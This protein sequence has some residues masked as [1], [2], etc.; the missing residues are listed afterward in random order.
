MEAHNAPR[1]QPW[2]LN[3]LTRGVIYSARTNA[4]ITIGEY[5]GIE[6]PHGDWAI[7]LRDGHGAR[8]IQVDE[9]TSIR[10]AA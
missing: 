4:G 5:L 3:H 8:S 6:A 2:H 7:L 9:L 10:Q 1:H